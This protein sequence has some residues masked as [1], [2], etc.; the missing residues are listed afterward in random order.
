MFSKIFS[1]SCGNICSRER[2]TFL[3]WYSEVMTKRSGSPV[4]TMVSLTNPCKT[5]FVSSTMFATREVLQLLIQ[6]DLV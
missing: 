5:S 1:I 2:N 4:L 6:N 3:A